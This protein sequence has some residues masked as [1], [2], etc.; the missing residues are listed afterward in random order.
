MK[1]QLL[2]LSA[3]AL[4]TLSSRAQCVPTCSNYAM[5]PIAFT[6][7]PSGGTNV[8]PLLSPTQDDGITSPVSIGFN[9][10]YY[11]TTY[12]TVLICSNGFIQLDI[13]SPPNL[14]FANPAQNFP[15]PTSP[16]GIIALNMGDLD[17]G[18]GGSITYTT[19]GTS[20]NQMFIVTFSNVPM[21]NYNSST[22]TGQI[23]LYEGT[24][25]IEI[26]TGAVNVSNT[27]FYAGTQGIENASGSM[28]SVVPGRAVTTWSAANSAYRWAPYTPAP[29]NSLTGNTVLCEGAQGLYQA[30]PMSGASSYVWAYPFGWIGSG[31]TAAV[32]AT[33]GTS[34]NVSV[35]ATY[36]CGTSLPTILSVTTIPAP[37]VSISSASPNVICTGNSFTINTAGA[38]IYSIEP[39]SIIGSPPFVIPIL[40]SANSVFSVTGTNSFGCT[41]IN[42]ATTSVFA[43]ETPTVTVNS[44]TVCNG[45]TFTIT[46]SGA[47]AYNIS[48]GFS[49]VTP[50]LGLNTYTVTGTSTAGCVSAPVFCNVLVNALPNV[51]AVSNRSVICVKESATLT[52]SGASTYS[53]S[54]NATTGAI[55]VSP[56]LNT[57]YTVTGVQNGCSN[58]TTIT[59]VVSQCV[60]LK[61]FSGAEALSIRIYPNPAND[62]A[63]FECETCGTHASLSLFNALGQEVLE[64]EIQ[65]GK[66]IIQLESLK[67][68]VYILRTYSGEIQEYTV[69][70][71]KH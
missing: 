19:V 57:T 15:D 36:T 6:T 43:N 4:I 56:T 12:S 26:H 45:A 67:D 55:V 17:P 8:V 16:N 10:D 28:G 48:G 69:L 61:E 11:C 5:A 2:L 18:M 33:V 60:G 50:T 20:P 9:F 66:A 54:T 49:I 39:G 29:P 31:T 23:I 38:T 51:G 58:Y 30:S 62:L 25:I 40:N 22:N 3:F 1:K 59:Q 44:G 41:S 64:Q 14:A 52:A 46:P 63:N 27:S 7:F 24:N 35:S 68:G 13:G 53:W 71:V 42:T 34:G 47:T 65:A 21:W 32:T 70:I 37:V